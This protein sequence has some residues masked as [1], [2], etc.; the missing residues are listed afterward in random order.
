M[1]RSIGTVN[2]TTVVESSCMTHRI[3]VRRGA[4]VPLL[5]FFLRL[6]RRL[7][8]RSTSAGLRPSGALTHLSDFHAPN[9]SQRCMRLENNAFSTSSDI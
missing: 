8:D 2:G 9:E 7:L 6:R 3:L 4:A 1:R 5:L